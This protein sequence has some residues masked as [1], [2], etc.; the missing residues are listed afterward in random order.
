MGVDRYIILSL[1]VDV[2]K[3]MFIVAECVA[4]V[5]D[6]VVAVAAAECVAVVVAVVVVVAV[7]E[8]AAV[9]VAVVVAV[10]AAAH[11]GEAAAAAAV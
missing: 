6:V 8:C 2:E 1:M 10:A 4:V 3:Q 5:V 11:T 7:A 9:V